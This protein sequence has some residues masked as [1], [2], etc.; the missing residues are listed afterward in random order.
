MRSTAMATRWN[1]GM[2]AK[3][4]KRIELHKITVRRGGKDWNGHWEIDGDRLH[5]IS[6]YGS[7]SAPAGPEKTR[8]D[9]A[10]LLFVEILNERG[11]A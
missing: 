11:R 1:F 6:A 8:V 7:R 5:V 4:A 10:Q 9:R 2:P 3:D